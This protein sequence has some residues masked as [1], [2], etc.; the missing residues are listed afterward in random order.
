[1]EKLNWL[2]EISKTRA[3]L[4]LILKAR[5]RDR[6]SHKVLKNLGLSLASLSSVKLCGNLIIFCFKDKAQNALKFNWNDHFF[7]KNIDKAFSRYNLQFSKIA[8]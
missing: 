5:P 3:R 1:M 4:G 6:L 2:K 7:S 8:Q